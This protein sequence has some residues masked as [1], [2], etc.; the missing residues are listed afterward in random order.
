MFNTSSIHT[1]SYYSQL[2]Y[3]LNNLRLKSNLI[4]CELH[5]T[6]MKLEKC[7]FERNKYKDK[8]DKINSVINIAEETKCRCAGGCIHGN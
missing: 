4:E 7:K 8:L 1:T 3:E 5:K 2:S 6:K